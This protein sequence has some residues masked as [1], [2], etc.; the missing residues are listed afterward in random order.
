MLQQQPHYCGLLLSEF[1]KVSP[2]LPSSA[3]PAHLRQSPK[4][5]VCCCQLLLQRHEGSSADQGLRGSWTQSRVLLEPA[6]GSQ[7]R[8]QNN[9]WQ[10]R[11]FMQVRCHQLC[12]MSELYFAVLWWKCFKCDPKLWHLLSQTLLKFFVKVIALCHMFMYWP[13]SLLP[14]WKCITQGTWKKT[15]YNKP[16][17]TS[18]ELVLL[19]QQQQMFRQK[20]CRTPLPHIP[21]QHRPQNIHSSLGKTRTS[22]MSLK[23]TARKK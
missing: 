17:Y 11:V 8:G 9:S 22:R 7:R 1:S 14:L 3:L 23:V 13:V 12:W 21:T 2:L 16:S 15:I 6:S 18:T 10:I 4:S 20:L 19:P 5:S